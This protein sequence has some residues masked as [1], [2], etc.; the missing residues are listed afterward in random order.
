AQRKSS[1]QLL[2]RETST[3]PNLDYYIITMV[4]SIYLQV[5]EIIIVFFFALYSVAWCM[6]LHENG[7][8]CLATCATT[9]NY[10][11][12]CGTDYVTYIN[13]TSLQ[14]RKTCLQPELG[15]AHFSS[16]A[17]WLTGNFRL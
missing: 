7:G 11:P 5:T 8:S 9:K 17:D 1:S 2:L 10:S 15:I 16:C 12:V 4:F 3:L 14:C 13:P 6:S